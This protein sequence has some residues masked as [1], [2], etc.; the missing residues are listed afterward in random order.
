MADPESGKQS[1]GFSFDSLADELEGKEPSGPVKN[2]AE[3]LYD[4]VYGNHAVTLQREEPSD[5]SLYGRRL[6]QDVR[7]DLG[8]GAGKIH[9]L[10]GDLT[11][12]GAASSF[13]QT[14]DQ[15]GFFRVGAAESSQV[16]FHFRLD[17][18]IDI[19]GPNFDD[20]LHLSTT[21]EVSKVWRN[22]T[23]T[24]EIKLDLSS[25]KTQVTLS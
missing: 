22:S 10:N 9:H 16:I 3:N 17:G 8:D 1:L 2:L 11:V 6:A 7:V 21:D 24:I 20:T 23:G 4:V 5:F 15:G 12:F 13:T 25:G 19:I 18:E 14:T